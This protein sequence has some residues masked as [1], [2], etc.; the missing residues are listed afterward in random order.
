MID[1]DALCHVCPQREFFTTFQMDN[2]GIVKID[3]K[4]TTQIDG[5]GDMHL[6][7]TLGCKLVL[8]D[9]T[10]VPTLCLNLIS[11]KKL[12]DDGFDCTFINNQ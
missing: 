4:G 12:D 3:Y 8:K 6:V 2:F 5:M 11:A 7:I 10:Y 1:T 9:V